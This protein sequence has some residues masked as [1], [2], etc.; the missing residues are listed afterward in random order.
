MLLNTNIFR[1]E[2]LSFEKNGYYCQDA[3]GS[4]PWQLYWEEQRKRCIEGYCSGGTRITGDHYYYLNFC[5]INLLQN[6]DEE[7]Q[8]KQNKGRSKKIFFPSFWDG[9]YHYFHAIEECRKQGHHLCVGKARRKGFSFKNGAICANQYNTVR[10]SI[11]LIA[12]YEKKYLY[13]KGTMTM[14]CSYLD[15]LNEH[16]GWAKKSQVLKSRNHRRASYIENINGIDVEKGYKSEIIA[17]PF[18]DNPDA[19]KGKDA[20]LVLLEEAGRWPNLRSSYL[21]TKPTVEDGIYTTGLIIVF[22]TG[23]TVETSTADFCELFYNP[24]PSYNLMAFDNI[25]DEGA[26]GTSCGFFVPDYMNKVGFMDKDGNSLQNEAKQYELSLREEIGK[27]SKDRKAL[28]GHIIEYPFNPREAFFLSTGNIFPVVDLKFRLGHVETSRR[29]RNAEFIGDL[30][31][32]EQGQ[33]IWRENNTLCPIVDFPLQFK[34]S[35]E[36]AIVIYDMPY[37]NHLAVVPDAMYIAGTDPYDHDRS[38]TDSLG[39]TLIFDRV[40]QK[41]VAEYTARPNTAKEYYENVRRLLLFYNAKVLYENE[42]KGLFDYFEMMN[43]LYLL[44]MEPDIIHDIIKDSRVYRKKGMHMTKAL[45]TYGEEMV[46]SWLINKRGDIDEED[47][48]NIFNLHRIRS[49]PLLKELI[50]YNDTGNFDRV[51]ALILIM[52]YEA[53]IRKQKMDL[54][55]EPEISIENDPFWDRDLFKKH[56]GWAN[57]L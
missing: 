55:K 36:G 24:G 4:L 35:S 14:T 3:W 12:A 10:N 39:S 29:I 50:A 56:K 15:F 33:V 11:T 25:W 54:S 49:V 30:A 47:D 38:L 8:K 19:L 31:F 44:Y 18:K 45:K 53:D 57:Y 37:R 34:D 16:T 23:S 20:M 40:N 2:A 52:Y 7:E 17:V 51:I 32:N 6:E 21:A 41:I 43:C 28:A 42:K 13:P 26:S 22:G 1:E 48:K 46:K 27:T 9:D 5:Q